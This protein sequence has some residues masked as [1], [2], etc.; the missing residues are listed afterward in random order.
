MAE[1][2]LL[3]RERRLLT[4][5]AL[6][7]VGLRVAL[8]LV[9]FRLVRDRLARPA[10]PPGRLPSEAYRRRVVWAVEQA[11]RLVVNHRPC[12]P[13]ALAVQW[14]LGRHGESTSLRIGVRR[15]VGGALEAHAWLERGSEIL[16]GG[17]LSRQQYRR[18]ES[19]TPD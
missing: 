11:G 10:R 15:G 2:R 17:S 4:L 7:L 16:I 6:F 3:W 5:A 18:F 19:P 9:P 8:A 13:Q 1:L 14:L 12:L